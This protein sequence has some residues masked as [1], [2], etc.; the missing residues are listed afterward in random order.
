MNELPN[1]GALSLVAVSVGNTRT[2]FGVF[3]SGELQQSRAF[4]N[5]NL[6]ESISGIREMAAT[7]NRLVMIASVNDPVAEQ[8]TRAL[9]D[10]VPSDRLFRFGADLPIPMQTALDDD[11][12]VGQ[13]RLLAALG[14]Y[15]RAKQA[16]V[17]IDAGT[18]ITVD[19]VDGTGVFQGGGIAPGLNLM[20]R[21][22]HEHTA[23]LPQLHYK[24]PDASR[25]G[26]GK[27]T[28][29]AMTLGVRAALVGMTRLLVDTYAE[30]Y[31]AYPQVVA[32]GG[33]AAV[34]EDDPL[35]EHIVPDLVLLG[36]AEACRRMLMDDPQCELEREHRERQ[37][38]AGGLGSTDA[39][40]GRANGKDAA[41][42][43]HD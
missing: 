36:I 5:T 31:G 12:T 27:D 3:E 4:P 37:A 26:I 43:E 2:R 40:S 29:H 18:A 15:S 41:E 10:Q 17:V 30:T 35:V 21:A 25:G 7:G 38:R 32:T 14:A 22:L 28:A 39:A 23:A 19:F 24:A 16:C 8:I 6:E 1:D 11:S 33:D 9:R 20:L 13:D 34:L 42:D